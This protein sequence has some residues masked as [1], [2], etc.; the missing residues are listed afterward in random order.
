MKW[1]KVLLAGVAVLGLLLFTTAPAAQ[2]QDLEDTTYKAKFSSSAIAYF[3]GDGFIKE[4]GKRNLHIVLRDPIKSMI[5]DGWDYAIHLLIETAPGFDC[6]EEDVGTLTTYAGE[7]EGFAVIEVDDFPNPGQSL[8]GHFFTKIKNKPGKSR[9]KT[10]AGWTEV[11]D[12][13]FPDPDGISKKAS[14]SAKEKALEK[15]G[16]ECTIP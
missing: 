3:P 7:T 15:L 2:A 14:L 10:V 9:F 4:G 5:P 1:K 16:L 11:E 8:I 13:I 6:V 12:G